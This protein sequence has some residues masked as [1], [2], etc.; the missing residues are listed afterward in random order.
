MT[1][2]RRAF[3][4]IW[5]AWLP[6]LLAGENSCEWAIWFKAHHQ[7]WNSKQSD[8][9]QGEWQRKHTTV[10]NEQK[11][12][13]QGRGY[14]ALVE[15]KSRFQLQGETAT[16][17]GQPDLIAIRDDDATSIEV[18]SG[19]ERAWHR[20]QV[21][22]YMYAL[23]RSVQVIGTRVWL[24]AEIVYP[25]RSVQVHPG[26]VHQGFVQDLGA[27]IRRLADDREPRRVPSMQECRLCD[28][29]AADCPNRIE[30]QAA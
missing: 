28:I 5:A 23:P 18:Q 25:E 26:S 29:T 2:T 3:P 30:E 1:T 15:N 16:L 20:L 27:L 10:L 19:A 6:R 9:N 8:F 14:D 24:R 4:Y 7:G 13:W 11:E 17:A 22:L 12:I 21:L